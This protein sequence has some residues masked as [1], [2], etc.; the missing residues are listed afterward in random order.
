[1]VVVLNDPET[2]ISVVASVLPLSSEVIE[3]EPIAL[4][5]CGRA[6]GVIALRRLR[7]RLCRPL[8]CRT[9]PVCA[10][11]RQRYEFAPLFSSAGWL[12][13]SPVADK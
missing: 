6:I 1:M 13:D 8:L 12:A 2:G 9:W 3:H 5:Q 7:Y 10:V 11:K 4:P